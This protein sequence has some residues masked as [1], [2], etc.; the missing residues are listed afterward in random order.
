MLSSVGRGRE[1]GSYSS[2]YIILTSPKL[3]DEISIPLTKAADIQMAQ[4]RQPLFPGRAGFLL[5]L[6]ELSSDQ[7]T[8]A[9][10]FQL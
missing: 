2:R 3:R 5:P 10:H 7:I 1:D 6:F 4:F 8:P 9:P